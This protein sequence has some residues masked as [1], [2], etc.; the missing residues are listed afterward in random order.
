MCFTERVFDF[1]DCSETIRL[2]CMKVT[3]F[4]L[5]GACNRSSQHV[6]KGR[7]T[8]LLCCSTDFC[9]IDLTF[10]MTICTTGDTSPTPSQSNYKH[11]D[12]LFIPL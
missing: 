11:D 12:I 2:G 10:N 7:T 1:N 6:D 5:T 9:N 4:D 3:N 8:E